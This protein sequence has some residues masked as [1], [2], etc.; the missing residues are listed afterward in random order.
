MNIELYLQS[1][2]VES[3]ALGL[4]TA[5]EVAEFEQLLPHYPE[6][7]E[8]LSDFEYHLELFAIDNEEPP[9]PGIKERI[10]ARLREIPAVPETRQDK[11]HNY[12]RQKRTGEYIPVE[13]STPYIRV[14]K[15]WRTF[16]IAVFILS[17][18]LLGLA[19]YYFLEYRHSQK[20]VQQLE[21]QL[22]KTGK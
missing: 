22:G 11:G 21:E 5:P 3:Y 6:L 17:K 10:E 2:I 14:H 16:F 4:A 9:P 19:I 1:G 12:R 15:H 13:V 7:R 20:H 18:I 8:V